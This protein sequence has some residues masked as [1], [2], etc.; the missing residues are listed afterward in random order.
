[1]SAYIDDITV[2]TSTVRCSCAVMSSIGLGQTLKTNFMVLW[3]FLPLF[4][5]SC[6]HLWCWSCYGLV[7]RFC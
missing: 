2:T 5:S 6:W 3:H 7:L 4:G 1:M